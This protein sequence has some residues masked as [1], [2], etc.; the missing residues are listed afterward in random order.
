MSLIPGGFFG[1]EIFNDTNPDLGFRGLEDTQRLI[2]SLLRLDNNSLGGFNRGTDSSLKAM[3]SPPI[4]V[5]DH[6]DNYEIHVSLPGV[7]PDEINL[8]YDSEKNQLVVKGEIKRVKEE[9]TENLRVNERRTG[10]FSRRI[11]LPGSTKVN[12]D[13]II[14]ELNNGVLEIKLPKILEGAK[15]PKRISVKGSKTEGEAKTK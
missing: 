5:F 15:T 10:S 11:G 8:D 3:L 14:A 4:D 1:N 2:N 7:S 13:N 9:V 6:K 12:E